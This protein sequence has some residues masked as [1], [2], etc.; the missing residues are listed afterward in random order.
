M[1][2]EL[3]KSLDTGEESEKIV[4]LFVCFLFLNGII[5]SFSSSG[6]RFPGCGLP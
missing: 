5:C 1:L 4:S 3:A 6:L 2:V